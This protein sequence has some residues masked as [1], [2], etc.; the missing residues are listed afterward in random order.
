[1]YVNGSAFNIKLRSRVSFIESVLPADEQRIWEE[2]SSFTN[3]RFGKNGQALPADDLGRM[4][5]RKG[6]LVHENTVPR[7]GTRSVLTLRVFDLKRR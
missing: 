3:R 1:M 7:N 4:V 2:W 6:R 5:K